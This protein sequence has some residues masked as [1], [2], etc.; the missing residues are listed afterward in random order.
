MA[1]IILQRNER[2][3]LDLQATFTQQ[4]EYLM[5]KKGYTAKKLCEETGIS[6]NT[7]SLF[8]SSKRAMTTRTLEK[9]LN[10]LLIQEDNG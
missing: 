7:L 2:G 3:L 4:L 9:L 6:E 8:R 10:P 1:G 5:S